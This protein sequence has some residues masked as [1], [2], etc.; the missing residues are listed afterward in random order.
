MSQTTNKNKNKNK[1]VGVC[2]APSGSP[3]KGGCLLQYI[4]NGNVHPC[5]PSCCQVLSLCCR[6]CLMLMLML[7]SCSVGPPHLCQLCSVCQLRRLGPDRFI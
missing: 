1:R 5:S 4:V 3:D 2:A 7:M 6:P